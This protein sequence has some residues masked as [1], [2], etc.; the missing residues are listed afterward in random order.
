MDKFVLVSQF[1]VIALYGFN[2]CAYLYM[3]EWNKVL[4]WT[5][6]TLLCIAVLRMK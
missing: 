6:A 3:R 1:V 4:Y 5:A 2:A